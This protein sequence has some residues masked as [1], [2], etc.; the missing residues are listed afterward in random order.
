MA[1]PIS[2]LH[3]MSTKL[4]EIN[5]FL[6]CPS[7]SESNWKADNHGFLCGRC[8]LGLPLE[9]GVLCLRNS[10]RDKATEYYRA[11]GGTHFV[12]VDFAENLQIYCTTR[13]YLEYLNYWFPHPKGALLDVGSGDGRLSLW[14]LKK[15]FSP[16]VAIDCSLSALQRLVSRV[17]PHEASSLIPVC[18]TLQD[19][20]LRPGFGTILCCEVLCYQSPGD[21]FQNALRRVRSLLSEDG[22][23]VVSEICR[24]GRLLADVVAMNIDNMRRAAFDG[25]RLEK[26]GNESVEVQHPTPSELFQAFKRAE[27]IIEDTRGISPI[28]MLFQHAYTFTSYPLRP[29]LEMEIRSLLEKLDDEASEV[30]PLSRNVV[31]LLRKSDAV[32]NH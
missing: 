19:D 2:S 5:H 24:H 16:V 13:K 17:G 27:L 29:P 31:A 10:Y 22:R 32:S 20:C 6:R 15:G 12:D 8:D 30:S 25:S 11:T 28:P 7:C 21:P 3:A 18:A 4:Q 14:A 26:F 9:G 23:V 1:A